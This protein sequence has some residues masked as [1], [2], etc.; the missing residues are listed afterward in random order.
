MSKR[1]DIIKEIE[2]YCY[3]DVFSFYDFLHI[4]DY[5]TIKNTFSY[6]ECNKIIR[7]LS[8][9]FYQRVYEVNIL[10]ELVEP[11]INLYASAIA[12][13]YGWLICYSGAMSANYLGLSF[14]VPAK[15]EYVSTG[16]YYEV[17]YNGII[18]K[19]KRVSANELTDLSIKQR[20]LIQALKFMDYRLDD[21]QI[22]MLKQKFDDVE[23]KQLLEVKGLNNKL[24][25]ILLKIC[26]T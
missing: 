10:G 26:D 12:R 14:Q 6:L 15:Y 20:M 5:E 18:I 22:Y 17:N 9:G 3:S 23:K 8:R 7:K 1:S 4:C 25:N 2:K 24:R 13:R 19:F 21:K 11:D 16:R